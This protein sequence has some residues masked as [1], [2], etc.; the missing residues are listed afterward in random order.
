MIG[1]LSLIVML[2]ATLASAQRG[3]GGGGGGMG[4][5][6][7]G[8]FPMGGVSSRLDL[9]ATALKLTKDQKKDVKNTMDEAQKE[10]MPVH[11]QILKSRDAIAAAVAAG[12]G[13][14][15]INQLV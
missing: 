5:M 8:G 1:K 10:A 2:V 3:G 11:E 12:K 4:G 15:E 9:M 13:Q 7:G 6:G 14:D